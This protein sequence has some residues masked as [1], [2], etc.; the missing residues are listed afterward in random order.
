MEQYLNKRGDSW[1]SQSD[2]PLF[3][4]AKQKRISNRTVQDRLRKY[5]QIILGGKKTDTDKVIVFNHRTK[6]YRGWK[7]FIKI[8]QELR[9]QRQDFKVFC[10]MADAT[11][12][13]MLRNTFDDIS[14]FDFKGPEDRDEYIAKLSNCRVGFHGGTRWA[15]SSQDGLC[16]GIPYVYEIGKET[17]EG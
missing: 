9:K 17:N 3:M 6:E 14:F 12:I 15:M 11:A 5:L 4:G 16:K 1:N 7:N 2:L 8:L 13:S 10:S